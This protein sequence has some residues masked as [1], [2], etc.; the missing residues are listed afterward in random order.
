[1]A[2][3]M[4]DDIAAQ[5]ALDASDDGVV[6]S[7]PLPTTFEELRDAIRKDPELYRWMQ[8]GIQRETKALYEF[9]QKAEKDLADGKQ[10]SNQ[11]LDFLADAKLNE[12]QATVSLLAQSLDPE[13]R[14]K[15]QQQVRGETD[16]KRLEAKIDTFINKTAPAETED[17]TAKQTTELNRLWT[18][19][20]HR[21]QNRATKLG[22]N[23]QDV[24]ARFNSQSRDLDM[25]RG[26]EAAI[27]D[28][29]DAFEDFMVA[30]KRRLDRGT[31]QRIDAKPAAGAASGG[32]ITDYQAR[33]RDGG[34]LPTASEIDAAVAARFG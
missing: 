34:K 15:L 26:P 25:A 1:M 33:L 10:L 2:E 9:R 22:V 19:H 32:V 13:D 23:Y 6:H 30:E 20:A 17:A 7:T 16:V 5:G 21:L 24:Y 18:T 14:A 12:I 28:L 11:V 27:A 4:V 29:A 8:G 3:Q 31:T